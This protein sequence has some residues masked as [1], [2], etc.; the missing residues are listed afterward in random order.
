M[1][2]PIRYFWLC[3]YD[4]AQISLVLAAMA[5][6]QAWNV[7]AFAWFT[8]PVGQLAIRESG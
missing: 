7:G 5:V 2:K 1:P 3:R 8:R 4:P 6:L